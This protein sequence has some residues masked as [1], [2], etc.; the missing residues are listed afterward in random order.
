MNKYLELLIEGFEDETVEDSMK[1]LR[2][3]GD[4]D[5]LVDFM[6]ILVVIENSDE[7]IKQLWEELKRLQK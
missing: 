2:N 1:K 3:I 6:N 4:L 7:I 5:E